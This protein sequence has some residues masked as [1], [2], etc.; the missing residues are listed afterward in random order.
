MQISRTV[1]GVAL[2]EAAKGIVV[3]VAGLGLFS[4]VH[5]DVQRF[6]EELVRH[7]HLN[8]AKGYPRI[9]VEFAGHLTDTR[10]ALLAVL[11]G[12]Y[13]S[14]RFVEAYGLW[15]ERGW[16]EWFAAISG[17]IYIPFELYELVHR[18]AWLPVGALLV[19]IAVV[20]LMLQALRYRRQ[21][22]AAPASGNRPH[23]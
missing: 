9:F 5:E 8:P 3:I 21:S 7:L 4:L 13:A 6:A 15:R 1:R 10:L 20:A 19:N 12:V 17:G 22:S 11:G 18:V 16:A 23:E 2:L 14:A